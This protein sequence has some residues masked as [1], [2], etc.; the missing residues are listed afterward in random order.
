MKAAIQHL[1]AS[2]PVLARIIT[3]QPPLKAY[4]NGDLYLDLLQS[5]ISQQ[6]SVKAADT[7]YGRFLDLFPGRYPEA[8][9][10]I[11]MRLE[12]LRSAGV[13]RQKAGYLQNVARYARENGMAAH[14]LRSLS[15]EEIIAALST[16]K[17]V[18]RWT[19]EMLLMFP[20]NR[21]DVF[22]VD[23]VGIQQAMKSLYRLRHEGKPFRK[24]IAKIAEA[25]SPHRTLACKYLW[26]W[27]STDTAADG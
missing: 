10:L 1:V 8:D 17:G 3:G 14:Q 4:R 19:V 11:R 26:R 6:L 7:I 9:R 15:D 5:I 23:D 21:P 22:P 2:D 13:S 16:I 27:R 12:R 24:R 20:L 25:W 18:G